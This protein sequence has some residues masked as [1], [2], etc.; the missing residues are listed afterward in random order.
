MGTFSALRHANYRLYFAGQ[1]VSLTGWWMQYTALAWLAGRWTG[2]SS[3]VAWIATAQVVPMLLLSVLGGALADRLP[4]RPLIAS[5][6]VALCVLSLLLAGQAY[7]GWRDPW[8]LL[9]LAGLIGVANAVDTPARLA[10]LIELVGR[11][12]L[13][14]A[15]ALNSLTFNVARFLGPAL[16]GLLLGPLGAASCFAANAASYLAVVGALACMALPAPAAPAPAR[17]EAQGVVAYIL[18]RPVLVLLLVLAGGLSFFAWPMLSLL[19]ALA[20]HLGL[21]ERGYGVLVSAVG[22]GS[23]V[24]ALVVATA[25]GRWRRGLIAAGVALTAGG[26]W[27][28]SGVAGMWQAAGCCWMA[29]LGLIFFFATGQ[30]AMQLGASEANR[31][32]VMGVWLAVLAGAHPLGHLSAGALADRY[33]VHPV[34]GLMACGVLGVAALVALVGLALPTP[35]PGAGK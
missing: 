9:W 20:E 32:R 24:G 23:L 3:W 7:L 31:G 26:L 18:A 4:R 21:A 27:G 5:A 28:L 16:A 15:V 17:G 13:A 30:T 11:D 22:G 35:A 19:P 2:T 8:L 12:D 6:Q 14:N 34:L 1:L 10:F 29:G 33:G 25:A